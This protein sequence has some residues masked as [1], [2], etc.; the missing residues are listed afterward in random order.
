[1]IGEEC[2]NLIIDIGYRN[3]LV[4]IWMENRQEITIDMWL[5]FKAILQKP[6]I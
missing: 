1:M 2:V 6:E 5:M 4:L 3:Q